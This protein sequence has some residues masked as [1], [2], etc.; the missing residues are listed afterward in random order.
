MQNSDICALISIDGIFF[1]YSLAKKDI[2][3]YWANKC[4]EVHTD[5]VKSSYFRCLF[6]PPW[7]FQKSSEKFSCGCSHIFWS[8]YTNIIRTTSSESRC[9]EKS[10]VVATVVFCSLHPSGAVVNQSLMPWSQCRHFFF[11]RPKTETTYSLGWHWH[12]TS[13]PYPLSSIMKKHK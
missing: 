2:K 7:N 12:C 5:K 4:K 13:L 10:Q 6:L 8:T 3:S 1:L 9:Q 11:A